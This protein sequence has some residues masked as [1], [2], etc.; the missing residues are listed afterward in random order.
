MGA[1]VPAETFE[2][3]HRDA[4]DRAN[5]WRGRCI[6]LFA[7][8]ER[9]VAQALMTANKPGKVPQLLGQKLERLANDSSDRPEVLKAIDGFRPYM[10]IR[11]PHRSLRSTRFR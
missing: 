6:N 9:A 5:S 1:P 11:Q 7:R 8:G 4:V 2:S 3:A 10:E